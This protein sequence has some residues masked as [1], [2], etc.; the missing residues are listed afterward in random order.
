M[1]GPLQIAGAHLKK[2]DMERVQFACMDGSVSG[3][4]QTLELETI[5]QLPSLGRLLEA[6]LPP[7]APPPARLVFRNGTLDARGLGNCPQLHHMQELHLLGVQGS[8]G[9]GAE[10]AALLRQTPHLADLQVIARLQPGPGGSLPAALTWDSVRPHLSACTQLTRLV[11]I[12]QLV[13]DLPDGDY[14]AGE[15]GQGLAGLL[16]KLTA[17]LA[18]VTEML[19]HCPSPCQAFGP[20]LCGA[21]RCAMCQQLCARPRSSPTW[22]W[23]ATHS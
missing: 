2:I 19:P 16:G 8:D 14:L 22:T 18:F 12:G 9:I 11:L 20:S 21:T 17:Q 7:A 1:A 13:L 6:L 4:L 23:G 5:Q 10:L 15:G 3:R